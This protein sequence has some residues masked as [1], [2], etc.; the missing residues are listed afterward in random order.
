M[1][2][3]WLG[4]GGLLMVS[5]K[6][7]IL[8]D[9][10]L[11]NSCA[12]NDK[13]MSRRVRVKKKFLRCKPDMII[14]TNS[15]PDHTDIKTISSILYKSRKRITVLACENSF[16]ILESSDIKSR[17][18]RVMFGE[19]DEWTFE[20]I[21]IK[22]IRAKTDDKTS[23]GFTLDDE[24]SEKRF[25][26]SGNTLY[27]KYVIDQIPSG[28]D[29]AFIPISGEY[30]CMNIYDAARFAIDTGA[31]NIVPISF[32]MFDSIDPQRLISPNTVIP[33]I[34][35]IIPLE[36][37]EEESVSES[38]KTKKK[39]RSELNDIFKAEKAKELEYIERKKIIE[40]NEADENIVEEIAEPVNRYEDESTREFNIRLAKAI[41]AGR[42]Y[43]RTKIQL[44]TDTYNTKK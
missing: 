38:V 4:Q 6:K 11:S 10:Y 18:T 41:E 15:H 30:G 1:K 21:L 16:R 26:Y 7:R 17:Y 24:M 44:N 43:T 36:P 34:Y 28:I 33:K 12:K 31:K 35:K 37:D 20:N 22:G 3:V 25:Y 42:T 23:F 2:I 14:L 32:G 13:N 39:K 40:D 29:T 8:V 27:S 5:G 19:G 9:P